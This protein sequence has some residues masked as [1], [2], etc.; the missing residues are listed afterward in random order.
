M[1]DTQCCS[2]TI[3]H[4]G[5]TRHTEVDGRILYMCVSRY[6]VAR[7]GIYYYSGSHLLQPHLNT[8]Q[9]NPLI[10]YAYPDENQNAMARFCAVP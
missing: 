8:S 4:D 10:R 6:L 5:D 3:N 7:L 1:A 9:N 2:E